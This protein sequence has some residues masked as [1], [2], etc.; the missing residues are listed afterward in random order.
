MESEERPDTVRSDVYYGICVSNFMEVSENV[1]SS[2][3]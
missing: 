1:M 3:S 2:V